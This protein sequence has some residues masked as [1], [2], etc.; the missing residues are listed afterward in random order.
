M[1]RPLQILARP[2]EWNPIMYSIINPLITIDTP[3]NVKWMQNRKQEK[4][5]LIKVGTAVKVSR[6][7]P[8]DRR[9]C[10]AR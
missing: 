4:Q 1:G 8:C 6:V 2:N 9:R 7:V 10:R 3:Q 5:T